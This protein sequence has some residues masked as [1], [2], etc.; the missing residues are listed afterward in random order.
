MPKAMKRLLFA[1]EMAKSLS[2][3]R[4]AEAAA[5]LAAMRFNVK[6]ADV[7]AGMREVAE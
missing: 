2:R 7:L 3:T 4:S 5:E 1:I 6:T